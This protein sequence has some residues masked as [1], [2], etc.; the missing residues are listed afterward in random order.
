MVGD[1]FS[2]HTYIP[3]H[4][5]TFFRLD[6]FL[7]YVFCLSFLLIENVDAQKIEYKFKQFTT[8]DGLSSN[9]VWDIYRDSKEYLWICTDVGLDRY[10]SK[11]VVKYRFDKSVPGSI[12][13]NSVRNIYE[14]RQGNIWLGTDKGLNLYRPETESFTIFTHNPNDSTSLGGN[15]INSLVEGHDGA[16]WVVTEGNCLNQWLPKAQSFKRFRFEYDDQNILAPSINITDVDSK[17]N[18]WITSYKRG[19]IKFDPSDQIFTR[20]DDEHVDFGYPSY[21]GIYIDVQD[22]IWIGSDGNGF[23][24]FDIGSN[25]FE[26]FETNSE[27]TGVNQ[28]I[29]LDMVDESDRYLLLAVDQ[30]GINRFDKITRRFEYI[31]YNDQENTTGLNNNGIWCLHKDREGILWIGTS[32]GG[33]N[34]YNP[35]ETKF[36]LFQNEKNNK[37]SLSYNFTG[38]F[39]EDHLGNIWIGTD[40][41]G[42]NI[43]DPRTKEFRI[44]QHDPDDPNSVSG[45][46]IR[47]IQEDKNHNMWVAT[48]DAGLNKYDS[49][50]GKFQRFMPDRNDEKSI[51][52]RSVWNM[53]IDEHG[54]LW[55]SIYNVG[56]DIFDVET[57]TVIKKYRIDSKDSTALSSNDVTF[58]YRDDQNKIW[59]TTEN[60]LN[61]YIPENESFKFYNQFPDNKLNAF[62]KDSKGNYWVGTSHEGLIQFGFMGEIERIYHAKNGLSD[63]NIKAIEEDKKGFL[64]VSTNHGLNKLD[65]EKE[66]I[67]TYDVSDGLQGDQFFQQSFMKAR[68]GKLYFGGYNGF[69]AFN[70]DSLLSNNFIP[71][72]YITDFKL[73]NRSV[74]IGI[75]NSPLQSSIH[76]IE[77]LELSWEHS[78][79]SFDF[80]A[81]NYTNP[82]KNQYK[83]KLQGFEDEWNF[84]DADRSYT[85]YTNLDPGEYIFRVKASNNDGV[86]NDVGV[87]LPVIINPPF[88]DTFWFKAILIVFLVFLGYLIFYLR[89]SQL[90]KV[91]VLLE[92]KVTERTAQ[93][94]NLIGELKENKDELESTNEE[95]LSTMEELTDQKKHVDLA[96]RQLEKTHEELRTINEQLD[97]RVQERTSKLL[98]VN[99]EL[100]KIVYSASHDLS[101]PLKSILGLINLSKIENKNVSLDAN[102]NHMERSVRRMENVILRLTQLSTNLENKVR[103]RKVLFDN[104]VSE[105]ICSLNF[106]IVEGRDNIIRN[107]DR[108]IKII[109]DGMRLKIVLE[110]LI[111]N[112]LKYKKSDAKVFITIS[113]IDDSYKID[114]MDEGIGISKDKMKNIFHMFYRGTEQSEG[115]GLG[116]YI[117]KEI[118]DKL[119][120]KISVESKED[121]YTVFTVLLPK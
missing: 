57:E 107:Y 66:E 4:N 79:F 59:L 68:S 21:K 69:N 3:M 31:M 78:V 117:T 71:P 11:N 116:L 52:G 15:Y 23:Y 46:V 75:T 82:E 10:D 14:D 63:N 114:I 105:V 50:T 8:K 95:L 6:L 119:K 64:W 67:T 106:S 24:S 28:N 13:S 84:T 42:I 41:G 99:Q 90:K 111:S 56:I 1:N 104:L 72:V 55:L 54:N 58:I 81:I 112:A 85:T 32:G 19:L 22:N 26:K 38:C 115:A 113:E 39:F 43:L 30:G 47:C 51:S 27:G 100:D 62:L 101:A 86:W 98:K 49:K 61:L 77:T 65:L 5:K 29:I 20:Y 45:D 40:G 89:M 80:V 16:L 118:L 103:K 92:G 17:G 74:P 121:E 91:N 25:K 109:A 73:F 12:S 97:S 53:A 2:N 35:K 7:M 108:G 76:T 94:N 44:L 60:G 87:S 18:I 36:E 9:R 96:N 37:N 83:Y 93:L 33:V 48:W 34:F 102:F 88:W 70:P 120:G 110:N